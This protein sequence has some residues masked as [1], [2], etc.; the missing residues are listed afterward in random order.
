MADYVGTHSYVVSKKA[1]NKFYDLRKQ[2]KIAADSWA[3]FISLGLRVFHSFPHV[4]DVNRSFESTI[5]HHAPQIAHLDNHM[6]YVN[7]LFL[8]KNKYVRNENCFRYFSE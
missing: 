2:N 3:V 8:R 4:T 7:Q 6:K 1:F 5:G